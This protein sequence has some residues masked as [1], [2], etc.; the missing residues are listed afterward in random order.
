MVIHAE[1]DVSLKSCPWFVHLR[2]ATTDYDRAMRPP[3]AVWL[4][5]Y[6]PHSLRPGRTRPAALAAYSGR[7]T[8]LNF[9]ETH[10][11]DRGI[12]AD[13]R[14]ADFVI[15]QRSGVFHLA[16]PTPSVTTPTQGV[17][18]VE[19]QEDPRVI[20]FTRKPRP[21]FERVVGETRVEPVDPDLRPFFTDRSVSG[22]NLVHREYRQ[23]KP[24][25]RVPRKEL[26]DVEES[27]LAQR[28]SLPSQAEID[29]TEETLADD[30][31]AFIYRARYRA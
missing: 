1:S 11:R 19:T 14:N 27:A 9:T 12:P 10:P 24:V 21:T 5:L 20:W 8:A 15:E 28:L 25:Y 30:K 31:F 26:G 3:G 18:R 16:Q 17:F 22:N 6:E 13:W 29:I 4:Y 7:L 23:V 2:A